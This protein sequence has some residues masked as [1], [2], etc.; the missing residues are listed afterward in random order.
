MVRNGTKLLLELL[1]DR[2]K[3]ILAS[4]SPR[5]SQLLAEMGVEFEVVSSP[6]EELHDERLKAAELCEINARQKAE[7]VAER[8]RH[9]VVLGA[10]TLVAY[11]NRLF[12]KPRDLKEARTMLRE[13]S[14]K[15]HEVVTGICVLQLETDRRSVFHELTRVTFRTLTEDRVNEYVRAVDVLDK[16]G[17]YGIQERGELLVKKIEGSFS[18][19]VGLPVE[20][21]EQ[22][23]D[24]WGITYKRRSL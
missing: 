18:N 22:E 15:T 1:E 19:V 8:Q 20:R 4:A 21:L 17:A 7:W 5:R 2:M 3:I 14:G 16:A 24:R 13:L 9:A 23:F 12:G 11:S 6:V 10:D